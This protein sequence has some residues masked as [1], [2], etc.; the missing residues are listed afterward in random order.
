MQDD[1]FEVM[2]I[3]DGAEFEARMRRTV[4]MNACVTARGISNLIAY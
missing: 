4:R 3:N 2:L 1:R